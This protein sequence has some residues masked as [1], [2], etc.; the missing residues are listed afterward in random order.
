MET[1]IPEG[2][3]IFPVQGKTPYRGTHGYQDALTGA[4][5]WNVI[6]QFPGAGVALATGAASGVWVLDIDVK[7]GAQG[8]ESMEALWAQRGHFMTTASMTPSGGRHYFFTVPEGVSIPC[9]AGRVAGL[10]LGSMSVAMAGT[11][12]FHRRPAIPG[13]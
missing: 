9:S 2:W 13:C 5:G 1:K 6:R 4:A 10:P 12:S 11:Q 3:A 8:M 7:N